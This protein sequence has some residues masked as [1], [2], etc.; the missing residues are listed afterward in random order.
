MD[1][2]GDADDEDLGEFMGEGDANAI[3]MQ[4]LYRMMAQIARQQKIITRSLKDTQRIN[5]DGTETAEHSRKPPRVSPPK[6]RKEANWDQA[7]ECSIPAGRQPCEVRRTMILGIIRKAIAELIGHTDKKKPLPLSPPTNV[8]FPTLQN[9]YIRWE[10]S[11]KSLFNRL[12]AGI[13]IDYI[14][15]NWADENFTATEIADLTP[16][17]AEHIRYLCRIVKRA[18]RPDAKERKK[19]DLKRASASSRRKT[20]YESRL[21]IIDRF[22]TSLGK[23]R[24]LI[25]QLGIDGTSSDEEDPVREKIFLVRRRPELSSKVQILKSKL[26]LAY[27]LYYK[28]PGTRGSQLHIRELSDKVSTRRY[29]AEG[30]PTSCLSRPWLQSLTV[31]EREFYGFADYEYDYSFPGELLRRKVGRMPDEIPT[32]ED[33]GDKGEEE[34]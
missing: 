31:P 12:A 3:D 9:F 20:I 18:N 7:V 25:V 8:L 34:L 24:N 30:L 10:E 29:T 21:K 17:V 14:K 28:G 23:H 15:E 33:E 1:I 26:D 11:E 13:A 22:P 32:S 6:P 4:N 19:A 16:M 27:G 2:D 5:A